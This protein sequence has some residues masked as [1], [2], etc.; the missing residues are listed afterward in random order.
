MCVYILYDVHIAAGN[1]LGGLPLQEGPIDLTILCGL[2]AP[3]SMRDQQG[4]R[5]TCDGNRLRRED[6][7]G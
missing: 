3:R 7:V 6:A 2:A 1:H 5:H 4:S